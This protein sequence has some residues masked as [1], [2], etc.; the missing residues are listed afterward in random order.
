MPADVEDVLQDLCEEIFCEQLAGWYTD[1]ETWPDD[2]SFQIFLP[3]VQLSTSFH[4][5]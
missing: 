4:A 2:L 3:V 1:T 5:R